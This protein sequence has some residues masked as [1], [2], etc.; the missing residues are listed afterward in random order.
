VFGLSGGLAAVRARLDLFGVL[1]LAG[2][3]G[4]AGGIT[5]DV[6]IGVPPE[7]FRD[8]RY[9]VATGV[10]GVACFFAGRGIERVHPRVLFFDAIGLS[11]F[12]VTGAS[13]ALGSGMGAAQ[14]VLLG[15]ITGIGGGM[16]RDVLLREVP[17]VLRSDLYA[18]P[19]LAGAAVVAI[20]HQAGSDAGAY[21]VIGAGVCLALRLVGMRY[22]VTVPVAKRWDAHDP[23]D[24]PAT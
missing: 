2:V 8:G 1:V 23:G 10:A 9:L 11:L 17:T 14:A 16:L 21:A 15:A 24:G 22:G 3:V 19:A 13:K 7:T 5:R 6:L 12:A 18:I 20:A 4:L